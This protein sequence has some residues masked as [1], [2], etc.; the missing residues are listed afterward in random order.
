MHRQPE[1]PRFVRILLAGFSVVLVAMVASGV[2]A[3]RAMNRIDNETNI[4]SERFLRESRLIEQLTRQQAAI[5]VLLHAVTTEQTQAG[6]VR[7]GQEFQAERVKTRQVVDEALTAHAT[8]AEIAAWMTVR[9]AAEPL[10]DEIQMLLL[11]QQTDSA[12]LN[13][14]YRGFTD[15]TAKL[16]EASYN[17]AAQSRA[18]QLTLDAG[19]VQSARNLF[20]VSLALAAVCAA[21]SVAA[22]IALFNRLEVQTATLA[23][24]SLHTLAEQE[25]NARRFSQDMHDEFGQALNAIGSTLSVVQGKDAESRER[26]QDALQLV[27]DAQTMARELSQVLRPRI[28]DDFGLD[29]GLRELARNCSQRTGIVVDYRSQVRERLAPMVETH[30]FRVAQEALT[31]TSR[32]TLASSVEILLERAAATV[33]LTI[34]DNGGGFPGGSEPSGAG[35]GLLGM[36]ERVQSV[37]GQLTVNSQPGKGVTICAVVP[38]Q[39]SAG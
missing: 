17:D 12:H 14:L 38:D 9:K 11:R 5:G 39:S 23:K 1:Y 37:G 34:A 18:T 19:T 10:F 36:R 28:L 30:L 29:A 32:H 35:L 3:L 13:R 31:N 2:I 25:E 7:L 4:L 33:R 21:L 20:L 22:S 26:L 24:L 16:M 8:K 15:A 27:K 6:R